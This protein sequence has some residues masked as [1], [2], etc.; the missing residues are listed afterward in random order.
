MPCPPVFFFVS[1]KDRGLQPCTGHR[2][3]NQITIKNC[4]PLPLIS[5]AFELLQGTA[6]YTKLD[7]HNA[8]HLVRIREGDE[9]KTPLNTPAGH[10]E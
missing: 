4:Y 10:F 2:G 5:S 7:L 1:K 6:I 9:W 8:Y 3:L